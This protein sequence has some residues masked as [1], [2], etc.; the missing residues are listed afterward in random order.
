[1]RQKNWADPVIEASYWNKFFT[2]NQQSVLT[3]RDIIIKQN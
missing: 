3:E 2:E 1:M